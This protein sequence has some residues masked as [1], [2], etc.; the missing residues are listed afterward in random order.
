[1]P[2]V[3]PGVGPPEPA[4]GGRD[5]LGGVLERVHERGAERG[6][7][8]VVGDEQ[9]AVELDVDL[10]RP[11]LDEAAVADGQARYAD[12]RPVDECL[13]LAAEVEHAEAVAVAADLGVLLAHDAVGVVEREA[14]RARA[15]DHDQVLVEDV[16]SRLAAG[17]CVAD[18]Q[19]DSHVGEC[20]AVGAAAETEPSTCS[21]AVPRSA[22]VAYRRSGSVW[23]AVRRSPSRR[24]SNRA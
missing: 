22:A 6:P 13:V 1:M 5:A 7:V 10:E 17:L 15:P 11:D 8:E 18:G 24:Q 21:T 9:L 3:E 12:A 19:F 16:R 4:E 2:E 20:G 14:A 23:R